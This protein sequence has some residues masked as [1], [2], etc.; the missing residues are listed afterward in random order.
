M[1]HQRARTAVTLMEV[2]VAT[3]ILSIGLISVIAMFPIGA[4]NM[5]EAVKNE[6]TAQAAHN[7][8]NMMRVAWKDW[9]TNPSDGTPLTETQLYSVGW[10]YRPY[11]P[12]SDL[13]FANLMGLDLHRED[14]R[15]AAVQSN[16]LY[17]TLGY[18]QYVPEAIQDLGPSHPLFVDPIGFDIH[19]GTQKYYVGDNMPLTYKFMQRLPHPDAHPQNSLP[20]QR[21]RLACLFDDMGFEQNGEPKTPGGQLDRGYRYTH[22]WILQR[23]NNSM[24]NVVKAWVLAFDG[25]PYNDVAAQEIPFYSV[26]GLGATF[27]QDAPD[28]VRLNYT[29]LG[30]K[31]NLKRNGWIMVAT[32]W[33]RNAPLRWTIDFIRVTS[34]D[35]TIGSQQI[36]LGLEKPFPGQPNQV[37]IIFEHLGEVFDRGLLSLK[38]GQVW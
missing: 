35:D 31:P 7:A 34:I 9:H 17:S 5:I 8:D 12:A 37:I 4:R 19:S 23:P 6:R 21:L 26:A 33:L 15:T 3:F 25:R 24:K 32:P 38:T 1:I 16:Q 27:T 20:Q 22:G 2:L 28:A 11:A 10:K 13:H 36:L 14:E 18:P 30:V 29:V